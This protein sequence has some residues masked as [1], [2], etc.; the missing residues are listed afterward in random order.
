M[1]EMAQT[2]STPEMPST[3]AAPRARWRQLAESAEAHELV[4]GFAR[5]QR[6]ARTAETALERLI[7]LCRPVAETIARG[8]SASE[9][10]AADMAQEALIYLGYHLA[11]LRDPAAFPYWFARVA[12][13]SCLQWLRRERR[14][15]DEQSLEQLGE[16]P[17]G[18]ATA[19]TECDRLGGGQQCAPEARLET[20][21]EVQRLLRVLPGRER[22]AVRRVYLDDQT[23][24]AAGR[25]MGLSQKAV[26]SLLYRAVRRL[27]QITQQCSDDFEALTLW[28]TRCG[29]HPL[30]ARLQLGDNARFPIR[31][32]ATCPGCSA[33]DPLSQWA[34]VGLAL[35]R[36]STLEG[37]LIRAMGELASEV[38]HLVCAPR[39]GGCGQP[40]LSRHGAD[41]TGYLYWECRRCGVST[42]AGVELIPAA[43]AEWRAFWRSTPRMRYAETRLVE[44]GDEPRIVVSAWDAASNRTATAALDYATLEVRSLYVPTSSGEE[45]R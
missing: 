29:G 30:Q 9:A 6:E 2:T 37:A 33:R 32:R 45:R 24:V 26:E 19:L 28:C 12:H 18:L 16:G 36:Y 40:M 15:R 44:Y 27:R 43:A 23:Q 17:Q 5:A 35:D 7:T 14:R 31:I 10:E 34:Y 21:D 1:V 38:Q 20:E 42:S 3:V 39:C 41:L 8:Y 11:D 4:A 25:R 22:E 13:S